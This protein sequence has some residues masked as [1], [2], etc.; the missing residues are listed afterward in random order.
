MT[1][2]LR[3]INVAPIHRE[4]LIVSDSMY[5]INCVT[6]WFKE[7]RKNNWITSLGKPVEN[8][9]LVQEIVQTIEAR[10]HYGSHTDFKWV[11]HHTGLHRGNSQA[12]RL[13]V[14]GAMMNR[15]ANS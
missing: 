6:K 12:D 11:K 15:T 3:A 14:E 7:W 1:A 9:D 2:I 13:A 5:A 4:V 8:R 10:E